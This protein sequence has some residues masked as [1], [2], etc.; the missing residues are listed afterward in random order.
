MTL[1]NVLQLIDGYESIKIVTQK[2]K[3]IYTGKKWSCIGVDYSEIVTLI[4]T[5]D[6]NITIETT[7][8]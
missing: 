3:T 4:Y 2:G 1:A 7:Q 6:G 8:E 5:T